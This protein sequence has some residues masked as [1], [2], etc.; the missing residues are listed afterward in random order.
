MKEADATQNVHPEVD[1]DSKAAKGVSPAVKGRLL[2]V[3]DEPHVLEGLTL[4]LRRNYAI[5]ARRSATDA[6]RALATEGP[7]VAV[8]SD[9]R[10]PGMDG[11]QFL[12]EVRR[13]APH[14]C[15]LLLTGHGDMSTAVAAVNEAGVHR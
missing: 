5:V 9:L 12:V 14:T 7:F 1:G 13:R 2:L 8:V 6:L 15:R 4:H 10:M 11:V 3:D